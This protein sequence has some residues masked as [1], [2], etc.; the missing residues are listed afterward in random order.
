MCQHEI[1]PLL[2]RIRILLLGV[3]AWMGAVG[4]HAQTPLSLEG[5][6]NRAVEA[7]LQVQ[8]S[9]ISV[10]SAEVTYIQRKFD[11]LPTVA[12]NL[13]ATKTFG[14]TADI[15]TNQIASSPWTSSPR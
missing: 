10:S 14:K 11:F 15:F 5:C 8:I 7:N 13:P 1:C 2:R 12:A 4:G 6:L 9:A 3:I